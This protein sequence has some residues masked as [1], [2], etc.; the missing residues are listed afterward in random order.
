MSKEINFPDNIIEVLS[1][2]LINYGKLHPEILSQDL[3]WLVESEFC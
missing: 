3:D 1:T 2:F